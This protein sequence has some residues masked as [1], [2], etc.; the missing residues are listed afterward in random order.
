MG[1]ATKLEAKIA[2]NK[3]KVTA[4]LYAAPGIKPDLIAALTDSF[5]SD[6][7]D[8][9]ALAQTYNRGHTSAEEFHRLGD[10]V[11]GFYR[12][13]GAFARNVSSA[14]LDR[15]LRQLFGLPLES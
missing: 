9:T 11:P 5:V 7:D 2:G 6:L 1:F 14:E 15:Y 10:I 12:Q 3:A 13:F 4:R 8:A